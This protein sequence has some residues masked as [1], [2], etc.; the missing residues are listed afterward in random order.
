M[1]G[2]AINGITSIIENIHDIQTIIA[3]G[4]EEQTA[5]TAEIAHAVSEAATGSREIAER[6]A[7]IAA[8]AQETAAASL[9]SR[10]VADEL[11][12]MSGDL[13]KVV[14]RFKY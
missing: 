2:E 6:I 7:G 8:A 4:V 13:Q 14:G 11:A 12:Q 3:S 9:S 10:E 1:A 5:T